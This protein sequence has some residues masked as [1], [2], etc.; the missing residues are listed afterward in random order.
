M[1]VNLLPMYVCMCECIV[2]SFSKY[3]RTVGFRA[4]KMCRW[5]ADF[6]TRDMMLLKP[7]MSL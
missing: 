1:Y 4:E 6:Y 3:V 7:T 2:F 5:I